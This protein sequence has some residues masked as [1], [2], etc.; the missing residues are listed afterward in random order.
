MRLRCARVL[1]RSVDLIIE[2]ADPHASLVSG[3]PGA[4]GRLLELLPGLAAHRCS[5][6]DDR[7]FT[8]EIRTTELPHLLEH[9]IL[10]LLVLAGSSPA[11]FGAT[12]WRRGDDAF[13]VSIADDDDIV[14]LGAA[15]LG[16]EIIE[17]IRAGLEPPD[18]S[19]GIA[20]LSRL[21]DTEPSPP[22][23]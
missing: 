1:E 20:R 9:V 13:C 11:P 8:E 7:A 16:L 10:E 12:T 17:S 6:E 4:A 21:R 23:D 15:R 2:V 3:H 22:R 14:C 18:L 5:T 19:D